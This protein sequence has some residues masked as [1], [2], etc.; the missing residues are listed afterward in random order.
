MTEPQ[1]H[2]GLASS[3]PCPGRQSP[4]RAASVVP[5]CRLC[6]RREFAADLGPHMRPEA[7]LDDAGWA[8]VNQL[9][10]EEGGAMR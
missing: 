1:T 4:V 8:C 9:L 2:S 10:N 5:C 6:S 7:L 3:L